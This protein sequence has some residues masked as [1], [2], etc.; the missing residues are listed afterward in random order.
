MALET[1]SIRQTNSQPNAIV[2]LFL[3]ESGWVTALSPTG[4]TR[5]A[6][7]DSTTRLAT[8]YSRVALSVGAALLAITLTA[9]CS[10]VT[11][12]A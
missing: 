6:T 3:N 1:N 7:S 12:S 8:S 11:I 9:S 10:S 2:Y 5:W 4:P